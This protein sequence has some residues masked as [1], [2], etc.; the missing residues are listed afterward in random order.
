LK[1]LS[2]E[3]NWT[4][5]IWMGVSIE[6]ERVA[7]RI[8]DLIEIPAKL[9]FLSCEPLIGPVETLYLEYIDWVIVGGESGP[10]ARPMKKEWVDN[11]FQQ[12]RQ[13]QVKFFFKQW[14][15]PNFNV[16]PEDPTIDKSHPK[17]AKGGCL[18]DGKVF[19]DMPP[20]AQ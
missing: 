19:H 10:G 6:E 5:N 18:F 8:R 4:A 3:L 20:I 14:G 15:R 1:E 7:F 16:N 17:H 2:A 9:K 12:C 11:I 13:H